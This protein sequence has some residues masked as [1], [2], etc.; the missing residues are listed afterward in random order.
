MKYTY[1]IV[2]CCSLIIVLA[3]CEYSGAKTEKSS[4]TKTITIL[5][6]SNDAD[7]S[8]SSIEISKYLQGE[9]ERRGIAVDLTDNADV[10]NIGEK[11][12][13]RIDEDK[14]APKET[15]T[16]QYEDGNY[17]RILFEVPNSNIKE[18]S[19]I[20]SLSA[21][22]EKDY[23][24]ISRGIQINKDIGKE[25]SQNTLSIYIGGEESTVEEKMNTINILVDKIANVLPV[26]P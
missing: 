15:I 9:L 5:D 12:I 16:S 8:Q 1:L 21:N 23:P 3:G 13:F 2:M 17:A 19:L 7:D 4:S 6:D 20:K 10:I 18:F 22:L 26:K 11:L 14:V 25:Q 24:G